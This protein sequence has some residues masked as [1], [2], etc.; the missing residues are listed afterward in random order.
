MQPVCSFALETYSSRQG[1]QSGSVITLLVSERAGSPSGFVERRLAVF[2]RFARVEATLEGCTKT[3]AGDAGLVT[4]TSRLDL[5]DADFVAAAAV[6]AGIGLGF[7][8][9]LELLFVATSQ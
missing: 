9:R 2:F 7:A 6:A 5:D 1:A 3:L 8:E 4:G